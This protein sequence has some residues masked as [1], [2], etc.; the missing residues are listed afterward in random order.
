MGASA[1]Y[2]SKL[3][4]NNARSINALRLTEAAMETHLIKDKGNN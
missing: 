2:P 4:N 3:P 1:M